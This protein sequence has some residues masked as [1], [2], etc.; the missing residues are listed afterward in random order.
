M[1]FFARPNLSEEQFKQL[2]GTTLTLSGQTQIKSTIGLTLIDGSNN[3]IVTASG[4]SIN[5]VLTYDGTVIKLMPASTSGATLYLPPYKS[6][7]TCTVGGLSACT[8][9]TGLTISCILQ[10]ILVPTVNPI[11]I[12]PFATFSVLPTI[13]IAEIG[14]ITGFTGCSIFNKGCICPP[15]CGASSFRSGTAITYNYNSCF[16]G[17]A[18]DSSTGLTNTHVFP[19]QVIATS[20]CFSASVSYASGATPVYNSS[21]GTVCPALGAGNTIVLC[22]NICGVLP[23]YFGKKAN[24]N[25]I[26]CSD[27][28]CVGNKGPITTLACDTLSI[29]YNST[30][31]DYL[32]FAVPSGVPLKTCWCVNGANNGCI[33]GNNNLFFCCATFAIDS[34]QGFWSGCSYQ[35]YVS[36]YQ[37]GTACNVPMCIS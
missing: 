33:G 19:N 13:S 29:I 25:C 35:V 3:I 37:T 10:A 9:I 18:T 6:P 5:N 16:S 21:G 26:C 22:T 17:P 27:I 30:P 2:S 32:W 11:V 24:C 31:N 14:L 36:C 34:C 23:W 15:Y 8:T 20:N 4:A 7:T 1:T 12:A 28:P